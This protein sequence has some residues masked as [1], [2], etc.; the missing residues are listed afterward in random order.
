MSTLKREQAERILSKV[1]F[2]DRFIASRMVMPSG[3]HREY[4]RCMEEV[5]WFL[6]PSIRSLPGINLLSL[7]DWIETRVGDGEKAEDVRVLAREC[8]DQIEACKQTWELLGARLRQAREV[9]NG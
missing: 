6:C 9:C 4:M 3:M 5:H 7:A 2:H 1:P 8:P